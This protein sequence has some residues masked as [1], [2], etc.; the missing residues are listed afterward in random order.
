[1]D[2]APC[3]VTDR[4][5]KRSI[6]MK[7]L[8]GEIFLLMNRIYMWGSNHGLNSGYET[9]IRPWVMGMVDDVVE[10]QW[11]VG[12][13]MDPLVANPSSRHVNRLPCGP[14]FTS[15]DLTLA[16][17][18]M[19]SL[20]IKIVLIHSLLYTTNS[21]TRKLSSLLPTTWLNSTHLINHRSELTLNYQVMMEKC[22]FLN[23]KTWRFQLYWRLPTPLANTIVGPVKWPL[24]SASDNCPLAML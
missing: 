6:R 4:Q 1:M 7:G 5:S 10:Q 19:F 17:V 20:I 3:E 18:R 14:T 8:E 12:L 24:T 23:C 22:P 21:N 16:L 11:Y 2:L 9:I 13:Q 15:I